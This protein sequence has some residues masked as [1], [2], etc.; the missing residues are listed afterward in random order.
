M[1]NA[2]NIQRFPA[3]NEKFGVFS[4]GLSFFQR[5]FVSSVG[6]GK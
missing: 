3:A 2:I 5:I 6:A 4:P 1:G